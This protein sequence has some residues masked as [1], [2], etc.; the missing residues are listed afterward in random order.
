MFRVHNFSLSTEPAQLLGNIYIN[1]LSDHELLVAMPMLCLR[2]MI[3]ITVFC[4]LLF[5]RL[6]GVSF[7]LTLPLVFPHGWANSS[8]YHLLRLT[9]IISV[10]FPTIYLFGG[11]LLWQCKMCLVSVMII[12]WRREQSSKYFGLVHL[13]ISLVFEGAKMGN[14]HKPICLI[15][16]HNFV[17]CFFVHEDQDFRKYHFFQPYGA[18]NYSYKSFYNWIEYTLEPFH[19]HIEIL[20]GMIFICCL[21]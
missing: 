11:A 3:A 1:H 5:V 2:P 9:S 20:I 7:V 6:W 19:S 16:N 18:I 4:I 21:L 14:T 17:D 15:F 8:I 13:F 10:L 12:H